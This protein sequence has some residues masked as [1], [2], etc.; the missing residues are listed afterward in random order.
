MHCTAVKK[1]S[2]LEE[3]FLLIEGMSQNVWFR[4]LARLKQKCGLHLQ[5]IIR[6]QQ[7][8]SVIASSQKLAT[9][10]MWFFGFFAIFPKMCGST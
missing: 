7:Q 5:Q 10:V 4:C 9:V 3:T 6:L 8:V 1:E 2:F